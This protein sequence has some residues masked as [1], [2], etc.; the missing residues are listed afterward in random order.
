MLNFINH[1]YLKNYQQQRFNLNTSD[2][3]VDYIS[4]F[5]SLYKRA[6][7]VFNY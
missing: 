6:E 4:W 5:F 1:D 7:K 2:Q 3:N